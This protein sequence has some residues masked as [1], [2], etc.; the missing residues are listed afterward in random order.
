MRN[1]CVADHE[2]TAE[3]VEHYNNNNNELGRWITIQAYL[4]YCV[5]PSNYG[6]YPR[7]QNGR[8]PSPTQYI[9]VDHDNVLFRRSEV[10]RH[11]PCQRARIVIDKSY[12]PAF[13]YLKR[14]GKYWFLLAASG[15]G[16]SPHS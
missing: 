6:L 2:A 4:G 8:I 5:T 15:R 11:Q 13:F 7:I 9:I 10:G 3:K 14:A 1:L 12:L 16:S